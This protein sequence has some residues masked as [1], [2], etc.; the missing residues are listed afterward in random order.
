MNFYLARQPIFDRNQAVIGYEIIYR[1]SLYA[2]GLN[3]IEYKEATSRLL[4]NSY[5]DVGMDT[6]LGGHIAFVNFDNELILKD[7]PLLLNRGNTIIQLVAN[8]SPS[9]AYLKNIQLFKDDGYLICLSGYG[10]NYPYPQ[11]LSLADIVQV[12]V[13]T[14]NDSQLKKIAGRFEGTDHILL[15][16]NIDTYDVY[17]FCLHLG[18]DLFEGY[19]FC[20]PTLAS[21]R[22]LLPSN[23]NN[24]EIMRLINED[25]PDIKLI[26]KKIEGDVQLTVKLLR[27]VNSSHFF[28][29]KIHSVQHALAMIGIDAFKNWLNLAL[30]DTFLGDQ[31]PEIIK[32]SM[33]RMRLMEL[34][35]LECHFQNQVETLKL[36]GLLSVLDVLL[37]KT[38]LEAVNTLPLE[39]EIKMTLLGRPSIYA[40]IYRLVLNYEKAQFNKAFRDA[41]KARFDLDR[42]PA[43]YSEAV[44]WADDIYEQVYPSQGEGQSADDL[45]ENSG[46]SP[47]TSS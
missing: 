43:L 2:A 18:F 14:H 25:V 8:Q 5:L 35:G 44:R 32:L 30:L 7:S 45:L 24:M 16:K 9:D 27:L 39:T 46:A 41:K 3:D 11:L 37:D 31:T 4:L 36:I 47:D 40:D 10:A 26:S 17:D 28:M 20:Q 19:Y 38:M 22:M 15:A 1:S 13:D 6:L 12:D 21:G 34:I 23:Y 29:N 33:V 42:L